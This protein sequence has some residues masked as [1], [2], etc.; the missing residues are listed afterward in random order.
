MDIHG[1]SLGRSPLLGHADCMGIFASTTMGHADCVEVQE[2][3]FGVFTGWKSGRVGDLGEWKLEIWSFFG[4]GATFRRLSCRLQLPQL[5]SGAC[6]EFST[7]P[8]KKGSLWNCPQ[9]QESKCFL[10]AKSTRSHT[11]IKAIQARGK[12]EPS[13][14]QAIPGAF[15]CPAAFRCLICLQV[16]QLP[17]L[18]QA[19]QLP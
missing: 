3:G 13:Q 18:P 19:F 1:R 6:V 5:P 2:L 11:R 17:Q 14:S 16:S 7:N 9:I 15:R 12:P 8:K 10:R 4:G